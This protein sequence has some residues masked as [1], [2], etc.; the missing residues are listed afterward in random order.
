MSSDLLSKLAVAFLIFFTSMTAWAQDAEV[1]PG[2]NEKTF[3]GLEWR[4]IGPAFM[5]GRISDIEIDP[6]NAATWYV[7]VGSG[8]VWKTENRGTSWTPLFDDKP[9]YSIGDIELD[10]SN[11]DTIWVG[12]GENVGGRHVSFGDGVYRSRNGGKSW[13]NMGLENSEHI[14]NILVHPQDSETVFVASQGPLWSGGGDRG[15]FKSTDGGQNWKNVLSGGAYTGVTEVHID[16]RDPDT[17]YAAT[18]QRLRTVAALVNGGPESGIHK[19]TDGGETWREVTKGLPE[20]VKGKIALAVSPANPETVYASIEGGQ[21]TVEFYRSQDRGESWE[22]RSEYVSNSTGPHYYVELW[23]SPHDVDVVYEADNSIH[24]TDDGGENL[25]QLRHP[26][27]HVDHHALAFDASNE[28]YLL[29]GTDGGLYESW[30]RG[31][32]WRYIDNLPVTQFYKVAVD[33]DEPFYNLYGGTQDNN[34]QGGPSRTDNVHGIRNQDW[35]VTL[36]GDGHQPAVDPSNPDIVYSEWQEGNLVRFDR[37]NGEIVYIQP[38]P[39]AGEEQERFN[40]DA[41]IYISAHDPARLY[42]ASQRL[43]RSDDRG[44][45]WVPISGDLTEGRDRLLDPIM[46]QVW[47]YEAP[48]DVYAMSKFGTI[49]SIG[50]SPLDENLLYVGTDDG[51]IQVT[52]DGGESWRMLDRLPDVAAEFFVNDIKADLHDVD[53]VYVVVDDH[54]KGDFRPYVYKSTDRG[55]R[56]TNISEDLP[57]RHLAWRLVQDHVDPDLLFLGTEFGVFFTVNGGGQWTKLSGGLPTISFR[58]LAIQR[59]E[60]DLVGATFGRGFFILD[61][62][63]ALRNITQ[64]QLD[65]EATLFDI[66]KAPWYLPRR[67]MGGNEVGNKASQGD[68]FFVAPNPPFGAIFTYHLNEGYQSFEDQRKEKDRKANE[69]GEDAPYPGFAALR[70]EKAMDTPAVMFTVRDAAG[71]VIRQIEGESTAGFHRTAWDLRYPDMSPWTKGEGDEAPDSSGPLAPPGTYSVTMSKR[72]DSELVTLAGPVSFEVE[73]IREATLEGASPAEMSAF[74][75]R[76]NKMAG[77]VEGADR[78]I[79]AAIEETGAIKDTLLRS[80]ANDALRGRVHAI[81]EQLKALEFRINGDFEMEKMG[82]TGSPS[83]RA[84]GSAVAIGTAFSAYGPTPNLENSLKIAE[85]DWADVKAELRQVLETQLPA[86]RSELNDAGVPWTP[87]RG[88]AGD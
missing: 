84:R 80:S 1:K 34:T 69:A 33:Y 66:R 26:T 79:E 88:V 12:T 23:A 44:D 49:T 55:R 43:W 27:K 73:S 78:A 35:F 61:D 46:G 68:G 17:M 71:E 16:P 11:P 86:I 25:R 30:D 38:Q 74:V 65:A 53:T 10:P 72:V 50:E 63:T 8:G 41:P 9:S 75:L 37:K 13:E 87:G 24:Y 59:R 5:S 67:P 82:A 42:F 47:A 52:E 51:R 2:F 19:S 45:S 60:N 62:Y 81:E 21:R 56:W 85:A 58:D 70:A 77:E 54:K 29:F 3:K 40:W 22:K 31:E 57:D 15:L 39:A 83:I 64:E 7:A 6:R 32:S 48:W 36:F 76:L 14:G 4:G 28:N 20:G 18:H